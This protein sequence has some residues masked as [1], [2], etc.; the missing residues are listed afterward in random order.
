MIKQTQLRLARGATTE[1]RSRRP[2]SVPFEEDGLAISMLALMI[3]KDSK[4]ARRAHCPCCPRIGI[5]GGEYVCFVCC[6]LRLLL[7]IG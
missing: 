2:S 4:A 6:V 1:H 3:K 5:H 7:S